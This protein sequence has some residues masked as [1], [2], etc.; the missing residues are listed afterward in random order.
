MTQSG[1]GLAPGLQAVEADDGSRQF[2]IR[3]FRFLCMFGILHDKKAKKI[4]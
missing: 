4:S 1:T 3:F 2:V